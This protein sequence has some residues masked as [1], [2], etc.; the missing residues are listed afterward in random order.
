MKMQ[1]RTRRNKAAKKP[2]QDENADSQLTTQQPFAGLGTDYNIAHAKKETRKLDRQDR[3][4]DVNSIQSTDMQLDTTKTE[5]IFNSFATH[6]EILS[7]NDH[8]SNTLINGNRPFE[9]K[10]MGRDQTDKV[11]A[12]FG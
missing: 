12:D 7:A 2:S 4:L 6:Q 5:P 10:K 11:F 9:L 8:N 1:T 3:K